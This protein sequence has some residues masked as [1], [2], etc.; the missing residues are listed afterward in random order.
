MLLKTS[1]RV[2]LVE[3]SSSSLNAKINFDKLAKRI[4][5]ESANKIVVAVEAKFLC[6][7]AHTADPDEKSDT[8]LKNS[9]VWK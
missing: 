2:F 8:I 1:E 3:E 6:F 5:N 4:K 7:N 9:I